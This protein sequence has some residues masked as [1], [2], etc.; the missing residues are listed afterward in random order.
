V[1]AVAMFSFN[2]TEFNLYIIPT[3][4][5]NKAISDQTC[6]GSDHNSCSTNW[7]PKDSKIRTIFEI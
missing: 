2:I 4:E 1:A 3:S 5:I 6:D 7:Q